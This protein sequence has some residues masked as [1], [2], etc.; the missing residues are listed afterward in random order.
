MWYQKH[1]S[2]CTIMKHLFIFHPVVNWGP[3]LGRWTMF[4]F[5]RQTCLIALRYWKLRLPGFV[6]CSLILDLKEDWSRCS[7]S[8]CKEFL[9]CMSTL[10][11]MTESKL[12]KLEAFLFF[13]SFLLSCLWDLWCTLQDSSICLLRKFVFRR[14]YFA[15]LSAKFSDQLKLLLLKNYCAPLYNAC[16]QVCIN[17]Y[18]ACSLL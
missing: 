10:L 2:M 1:K 9:S 7:P 17:L 12:K 15:Y 14:N 16:F 5:E 13:F 4:L 11:Y 18:H 3:L 8:C 6:I